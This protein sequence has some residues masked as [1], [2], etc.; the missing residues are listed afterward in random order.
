MYS[1]NNEPTKDTPSC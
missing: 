1:F